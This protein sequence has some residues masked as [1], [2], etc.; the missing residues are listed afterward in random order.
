MHH[1]ATKNSINALIVLSLSEMLVL[2]PAEE[3]ERCHNG[4][5]VSERSPFDITTVSGQSQH[6]ET[7]HVL[8]DP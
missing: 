2:L 4:R 5:T 6:V 7:S 1:S 8:T 3:M